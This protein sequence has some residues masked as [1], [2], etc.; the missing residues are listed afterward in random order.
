MSTSEVLNPGASLSLA[1]NITGTMLA[2]QMQSIYDVC[3]QFGRRMPIEINTKGINW[4]HES[5]SLWTRL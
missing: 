2:L 1:H 4:A 5:G 3:A